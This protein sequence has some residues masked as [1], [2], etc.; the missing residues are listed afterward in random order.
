[1]IDGLKVTKAANAVVSMLTKMDL[2]FAEA[3]DAL[4]LARH[5]IGDIKIAQPCVP[6][7]SDLASNLAHIV[8]MKEVK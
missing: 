2:T 6:N 7:L 3:Q 1:M 4:E 8:V 5:N